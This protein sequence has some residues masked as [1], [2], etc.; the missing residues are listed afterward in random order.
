M[1]CDS[2]THLFSHSIITMA[3]SP[4][5]DLGYDITYKSSSIVTTAIQQ[6][7]DGTNVYNKHK[8]KDMRQ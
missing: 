8:E 7:W 2:I 4:H 6:P 1:Q 3:P 5:S